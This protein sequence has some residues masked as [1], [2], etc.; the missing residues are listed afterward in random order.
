MR[1]DARDDAYGWLC[2]VRENP[3]GQRVTNNNVDGADS[4]HLLAALGLSRGEAAEVLHQHLMSRRTRT[5]R[6][7]GPATSAELITVLREYAD[8]KAAFTEM[9]RQDNRPPAHPENA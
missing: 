9:Q 7:P 6:T 5:S 4:A 8:R 3:G 1:A 2:Q